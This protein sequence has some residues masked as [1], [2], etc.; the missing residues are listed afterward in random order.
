MN[1]SACIKRIKPGISFELPENDLS[2]LV[3][4]D[5]SP[6]PTQAEI[7]TEW[8]ILQAERVSATQ[9]ELA[10]YNLSIAIKGKASDADDVYS[11]L[12]VESQAAFS[13]LYVAAK[14]FIARGRMDVAC[15]IISGATVPQELEAS[16]QAILT[17]LQ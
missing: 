9:A 2:T 7:E 10:E 16:R 14:D 12:P 5:A 3:W 15:A 1:I 4:T 17:C 6:A 11:A 13:T 8:E